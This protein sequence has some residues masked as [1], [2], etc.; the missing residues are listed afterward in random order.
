MFESR[1]GVFLIAGLGFFGLSFLVMAVLPWAIY[2][3]EP[4]Q[5]VE[6]LAA[7]GIIPEFVDLAERYPEQFKQY[8]GAPTY[9]TYVEALRLGHQV[10]VAEACWHCH[11]QFIRPV[12][13]EDLR[14]GPVS[15][16]LEYQNELQRPVLFGTRR[17]GPDLSREAGRRSNDWHVAHFWQPTSVVPSSVMPPYRWFFDG[18]G[19]PNKRGLAVITY[20]QFLG[21]WLKE[22]PYFHGEGPLGPLPA[23][24]PADAPIARGATSGET[25]SVDAPI[26]GAAT[27]GV[28]P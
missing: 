9:A 27:A 8:F 26:V 17:V 12:S 22:Y 1:S 15:H 11:S 28:L 6:Q 24:T 18:Q 10:Y 25:D 14:W 4:E 2:Y 20:V 16:A 13:N 7:R 19:Y 21:S 3:K 5:T 23:P